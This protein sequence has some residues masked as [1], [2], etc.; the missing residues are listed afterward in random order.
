MADISFMA[1]MRE[2][3]RR[4]TGNENLGTFDRMLKEGPAG[5]MPSESVVEHVLTQVSSG[6][7]SQAFRFTCRY[8]GKPAGVHKSSTDWSKRMNWEKGRVISGACS[9][10]SETEEDFSQM[11][12]QR[13]PTM[14]VTKAYRFVGGE[15]PWY[16]QRVVEHMVEVQTSQDEQLLYRFKLVYEP[17]LHC[18]LIASVS[19][20]ATSTERFFPGAEGCDAE[21]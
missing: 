15:A 5:L 8:P 10:R 1:L 16:Q 3:Q 13:Y 20:I 9:G 11:L 18:H 17:L 19:M 6:N 21:I 14:L 2:A 4:D 7:I 12:Q